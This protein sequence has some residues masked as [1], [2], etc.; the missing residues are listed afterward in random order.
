MSSI[1]EK[2]L[3]RLRRLQDSRAADLA[4]TQEA[5][6][7]CGNMPVTRKC[8]LQKE[9]RQKMAVAEALNMIDELESQTGSLPLGKGGKK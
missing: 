2:E 4:E 8:L 6:K 9:A 7:L 5:L 3:A 1:L